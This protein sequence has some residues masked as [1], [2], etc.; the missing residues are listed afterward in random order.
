MRLPPKP[1]KIV[2]SAS[3]CLV[4]SSALQGTITTVQAKPIEQWKAVQKSIE[5][6]A[7]SVTDPSRGSSMRLA[8][9]QRIDFPPDPV[10]PNPKGSV[11]VTNPNVRVKV[12]SPPRVNIK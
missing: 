8:E 4:S 11:K 12:P 1:V 9:T 5:D 3:I 7:A 6:A 10:P 2:I